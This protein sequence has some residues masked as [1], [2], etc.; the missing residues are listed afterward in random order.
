MIVN[1][2]NYVQGHL[3]RNLERKDNGGKIPTNWIMHVSA[4]ALER[5]RRNR[6]II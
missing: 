5:K 4:F 6:E 1:S 3:F 2:L